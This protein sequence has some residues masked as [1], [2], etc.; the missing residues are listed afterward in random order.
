MIVDI[1]HAL[2]QQIRIIDGT[3]HM[4]ARRLG[5]ELAGWLYDHAWKLDEDDVVTLV[6]EYN[7]DK[8][9]GAADLADLLVDE[10]GL[11]H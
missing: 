8:N 7:H 4:A 6:D 3:N 9:M 10:L 1:R 2:A 11:D 5:I